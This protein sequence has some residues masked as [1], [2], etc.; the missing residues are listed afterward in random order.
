MKTDR[1]LRITLFSPALSA[2]GAERV[3]S[4]LAN[5]LAAEGHVITLITLADRAR[6]FFPIDPAIHRVGLA[7]QSMSGGLLDALRNNI[8]RIR[9]LRSALRGSDPEVLIAFC[10]QA[11]VLALL[12]SRGLPCRVIVSERTD[13][14]RHDIG[15]LWSS[16]RRLVY[17]W[18]DTVVVQT[19]AVA[20]WLCREIPRAR[21]TV[22]PNPVL[23][24]SVTKPAN[25]AQSTPPV[26]IGMGRLS[27]EKGFDRLLGAFATVSPTFPNWRLQLL[28]DG[29]L[30]EALQSEAERLGIA[31]RV[32]FLGNVA[33]PAGHL[34]AAELFVL[35]SRYEGFPNALLE[36]MAAGLPVLAF[37]CP[38][39]PAAI[40]RPNVDGVLVPADDVPAL[41]EQMAKLMADAGERQRLGRAAIE[42]LD[43]FG[44]PNL[45]K[46]W[47]NLMN[48]SAG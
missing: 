2:G 17:P 37:D 14:S 46:Q 6:D 31:A 5:A 35:P 36:A 23:P 19:D 7:V 3:L 38:S 1:S 10:D 22:I 47:I 4:L 48:E 30:R 8:G 41:Q 21:V 40:I 25:S 26:I 28:G 34:A 45:L 18:A 16:L 43:R 9:R 39:G 11:N 44:L 12:A 13:P 42:V 15:R 29:P 20:A 27:H 32:S 24:P 33:E